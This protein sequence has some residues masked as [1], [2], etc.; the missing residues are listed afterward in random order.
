MAYLNNAQIMG[1][2]GDEPKIIQAQNGNIIATISLATTEKGYTKQDGTQIPDKTEWHNV[3]CFGRLA[4][5]VHNY[6]HKGSSL[7]ISGKLRTRSYDDR[8]GVKKYVT[9]IHAD[10]LQMLDRRPDSSHQQQPGYQQPAQ[11]RYPDYEPPF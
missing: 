7:Y 3:V 1:F 8:N 9:E 2:A 4:D 10:N 5:V 11:Q 6:V